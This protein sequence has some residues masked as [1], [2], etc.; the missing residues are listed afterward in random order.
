M[1]KK[2]VIAYDGSDPSK[3][4][5]DYAISFAEK[6]SAQLT[7][8][9]VVR[10]PEVP[11]DVETEAIIDE[12]TDSCRRE[13]EQMK[14]AFAEKNIAALFEVRVGHPA[15]QIVSF[16]DETKADLI[17]MGHRGRTEVSRW[18]LGSISKRVMSYAHCSVFL[19]R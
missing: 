5:L 11:D 17:V 10:I 6:Y 4:A 1:I 13:F 16:A 18:L 14:S 12:A 9:S 7:V 8:L 2:I 3:K 15:D 19:V